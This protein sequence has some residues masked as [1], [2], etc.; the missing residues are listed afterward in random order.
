M[1]RRNAQSRP[2]GETQRLTIVAVD[3]EADEACL[4]TNLPALGRRLATAVVPARPDDPWARRLADWAR[5]RGIPVDVIP[6][7]TLADGMPARDRAPEVRSSDLLIADPGIEPPAVALAAALSRRRVVARDA[8]NATPADT[9]RSVLVIEDRTPGTIWHTLPV[10]E[11]C[12]AAGASVGVIPV[13]DAVLARFVIAKCLL[14]DRVVRG[15]FALSSGVYGGTDSGALHRPAGLAGPDD[16]DTADLVGAR[17]AVL[18]VNGHSNEF[19]VG[20]GD[21][22]L[23]CARESTPEVDRTASTRVLAC[24]HDGVCHRQS[25]IGLDGLSTERL[26]S[27][28]DVHSDVL[29]STGCNASR[30]V[31]GPSDPAVAFCHQALAGEQTAVVASIGVLAA[32]LE[33]DFLFVALLADG[34]TLGDAVSRV[35]D[36]RRDRFGQLRATPEASDA[37]VLFGSPDL[38]VELPLVRVEPRWVDGCATLSLDD[39]PVH[40]P[41]GVVVR[42]RTPPYDETPIVLVDAPESIWVRGVWTNGNGGGALYLWVSGSDR[43]GA[44]LAVRLADRSPWEAHATALARATTQHAFWSLFLDQVLERRRAGS[45]DVDGIA[46]IVMGLS[47]VLRSLT[48]GAIA[49]D[50]PR[51]LV[52]PIAPVSRAAETSWEQLTSLTATLLDQLFEHAY[53]QGVVSSGAWTPYFR[54]GSRPIASEP[55]ACGSGTRTGHGYESVTRDGVVRATYECD[56]CG[57]VA[58]TDGRGLLSLVE[59]SGVATRGSIFRCEGRVRAPATEAV[60]FAAIPLIAGERGHRHAA[61]GKLASST[62]PAGREARVTFTLEISDDMPVGLHNFAVVAIVNVA[63]YVLRHWLEIR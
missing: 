33:L 44:S 14:F 56:A 46:E 28:S 25:F 4:L 38:E 6:A 27:A 39:M 2:A 36:E 17:H 11:A 57:K 29:I 62:V 58:D 19:D 5:R 34:Y 40:D 35:N 52:T 31:P 15:R 8:L 47:R 41:T 43:A 9:V 45:G 20:L 54:R 59:W 48:S 24:F 7:S 16:A 51:G 55:C 26:F 10:I 61:W 12:R 32:S 13:T 3:S 63:P 37:F 18:V 60:L 22:Q 1:T 23:I 49:L 21:D 42:M 50:P 30:V 53:S